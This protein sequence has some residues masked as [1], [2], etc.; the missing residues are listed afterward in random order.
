M[1]KLVLVD[2]K[3]IDVLN[4]DIYEDDYDGFSMEIFESSQSILMNRAM[5]LINGSPAFVSFVKSLKPVKILEANLSKTAK[6]MID[7]GEWVLRYSKSKDGFLPVLVDKNGKYVKQVVLTAKTI[8]PQLE[9]SLNAL[10][11]QQQLAQLMRQLEIMNNSIQRIERGQRADRIGLY[12][13]ARQQFIEA[14]SM[15]D[16]TLQE[17]GMLNAA[18][19]ANDSRFQLMQSMKNDIK[20][21]IGK[22]KIS[23]K[24]KDELSDSIRESMRYI[25]D[26]TILCVAAFSALG[27]L[28]P[29]LAALMSYRS[30]IEKTL[31][32]EIKD[33]HIK[34]CE[35]LHSNWPGNDDEWLQMPVRLVD[36]LKETIQQK[37]MTYALQEDTENES[38]QIS[39]MS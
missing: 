33:E 18:K 4:I 20:Q 6:Q 7:K 1:D 5:R 27:E 11:S 35:L 28:K 24:E 10:A 32:E 17:H 16:L 31:L 26:S 3:N 34:V 15:S 9:N 29:M 21:I 39:G 23:K 19:T 25:N 13:S 8:T 14:A 12:Y 30:F 2:P 22:S 38:M 36:T 37:S